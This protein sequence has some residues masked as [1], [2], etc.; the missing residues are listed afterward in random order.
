MSSVLK[1]LFLGD[2]SINRDELEQSNNK[3][4]TVLDTYKNGEGKEE[5]L[6]NCD[7]GYIKF[8]DSKAFLIV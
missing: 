8:F 4:Y 5:Y 2:N 3:I 1:V 6:I 7:L